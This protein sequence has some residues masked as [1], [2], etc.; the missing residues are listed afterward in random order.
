MPP[1]VRF[2][3]VGNLT[4]YHIGE[5]VWCT[6]TVRWV[7]SGPALV[8]DSLRVIG[9]GCVWETRVLVSTTNADAHLTVLRGQGTHALS[10][11]QFPTLSPDLAEYASLMSHQR[12]WMDLRQKKHYEHLGRTTL[13]RLITSGLLAVP[14]EPLS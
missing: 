3:H 8:R 7:L 14:S 1:T 10:P 11:G 13:E 2:D 9:I 4:A 5:H 6:A 12:K